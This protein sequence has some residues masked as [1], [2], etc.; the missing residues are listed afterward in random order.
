MGKMLKRI[1]LKL[2]FLFM[3]SLTMSALFSSIFIHN[4]NCEEMRLCFLNDNNEQFN[5]IDIK[6][7]FVVTFH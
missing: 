6:V 7:T 2:I 1:K 4:S 3:L 5:F